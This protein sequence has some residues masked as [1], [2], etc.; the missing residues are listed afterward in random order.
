MAQMSFDKEGL[1]TEPCISCDKPHVDDLFLEWICD[2][3]ECKH[4]EKE[5]GIS[6]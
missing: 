6:N 4:K 5:D 3:K 1:I 2:E